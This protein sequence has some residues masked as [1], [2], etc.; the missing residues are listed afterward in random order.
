MVDCFT[1]WPDI[2][3]MGHDATTPHLLS[4]LKQAFCRSGAPDVIWSDQG[5]QFTSKV[6]NDFSREWGF[7]HITSTPTYPQSNGKAEATIKSMKKIFRAAWRFTAGHR[8]V[9]LGPLPVSK[10]AITEGWTVT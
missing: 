5:P 9:G 3:H 10:H 2:V 8:E 7:Q 6:F 4:A 1:D